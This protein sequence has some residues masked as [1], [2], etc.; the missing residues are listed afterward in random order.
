MSDYAFMANGHAY[1]PNQTVV[2]VA[3]ADAHNRAIERAELDLWR[4]SPAR[5]LAYY[6][7]PFN[8]TGGYRAAFSPLLGKDARVTTW[9]GSRLGAIIYARVYPHNFGS[10][11]V[12]LRVQGS[13]GSIYSGRASYDNGSCIHL[14]RVK[15]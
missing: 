15:Q 9:L 12:A 10:R 3:E 2:L 6:S 7:F 1:T 8:L 5:M 11:M 4:T 13:N 14:R